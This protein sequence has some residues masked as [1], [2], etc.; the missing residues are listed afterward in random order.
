[1]VTQWSLPCAAIPPVTVGCRSWRS[2][3]HRFLTTIVKAE[4]ELPVDGEA[5]VVP[6][7]SLTTLETLGRPSDATLGSPYPEVTVSVRDSDGAARVRL[8][9]GRGAEILIDK[10]VERTRLHELAPIR[11]SDR[12]SGAVE[13]AVCEPT[14]PE[15]YDWSQLQTAQPDQRVAALHGDEWIAVRGLAREI[16]SRLPSVGASVV[17]YRGS[18]TIEAPAALRLETVHIRAEERRAVLLWRHRSPWLHGDVTVVAGIAPLGTSP[19]FPRDPAELDPSRALGSPSHDAFRGTSKISAGDLEQI[20]AALASAAPFALAGSRATGPI[21]ARDPSGTP[22][23]PG[24]SPRADEVGSFRQTAPLESDLVAVRK[25]LESAAPFAISQERP[26]SLAADIPDAPWAA[27]SA[28]PLERPRF[29]GTMTAKDLRAMRDAR[30][31][32]AALPSSE[33]ALPSPEAALPSPEAELPSPEAELPELALARDAAPAREVV[34]ATPEPAIPAE[35]VEQ[36]PAANPE[37]TREAARRRR[38]AEAERFAKEQ[39]E[40]TTRLPRDERAAARNVV[41]EIY[42]SLCRKR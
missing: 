41:R 37:L 28:P 32:L 40:A 17:F 26:S 19:P 36:S 4:L 6:A 22:F 1:M 11:E 27:A 14:V 35:P 24:A 25:L 9:V 10:Q 21:A 12:L 23:R 2:G 18:H 38:M 42:A 16:F 15:T 31:A 8:L 29:A 34:A 30:E 5:L 7:S 39:R 33:A 20:Q 13:F 3:G